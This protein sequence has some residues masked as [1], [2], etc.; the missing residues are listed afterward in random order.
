MATVYLATLRTPNFTFEAVAESREQLEPALEAAWR[1]HADEHAGMKHELLCFDLVLDEA[2][3]PGSGYELEV[4]ALT[5]GRV[6]RDG[7]Q[8]TADEPAQAVPA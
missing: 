4:R 6:Y 8:F 7:V 1:Q 3:R 5:S 2:E